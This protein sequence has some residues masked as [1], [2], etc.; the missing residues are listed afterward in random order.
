MKIETTKVSFK[1]KLMIKKMRNQSFKYKENQLI[2]Y[3]KEYKYVPFDIKSVTINPEYDLEIVDLKYSKGY[4][5]KHKNGNHDNVI[6]MIHGGAY[7]LPLGPSNF[8]SAYLYS[9]Y[10]NYS[11][12]FV[13]DYRVNERF[14]KGIEDVCEGYDYLLTRYQNTNISVAGHSAGGGLAMALAFHVREKELLKPRC[15]ILAS[16]WLDITCSG[17]SYMKNRIVDTLF[18]SL[19][20]QKELTIPNFYA[21]K[22]YEKNEYVSPIFGKFNDLPPI[23]VTTGSDEMVLS[24]SLSLEEKCTEEDSFAKLYVYKGMWHD[25]YTKTDDF[26]EAK[27]AWKNIEL[28]IKNLE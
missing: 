13:I 19:Y 1:A 3:L 17:Q 5:L 23:L 18:G 28:F 22:E 10:S 21:D 26:K 14:P 11:D 12:V 27:E 15:L 16:P 24:D 20:T 8:L 25:F 7:V 2:K 6:Y 4:L 9:A